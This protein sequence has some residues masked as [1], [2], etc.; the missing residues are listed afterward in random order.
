M[1]LVC[2]LGYCIGLHGF[3]RSLG[4]FVMN[5]AALGVFEWFGIM[6]E[7]PREEWEQPE[8]NED[9]DDIASQLICRESRS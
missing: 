9:I 7:G 1:E 3:T 5:H 6:V 4:V 8:Y 2:G